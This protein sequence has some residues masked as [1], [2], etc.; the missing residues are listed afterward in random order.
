VTVPNPNPNSHPNPHLLHVNQPRVSDC[1]YSGVV[2]E[3]ELLSGQSRAYI[4]VVVYTMR[5]VVI[6]L[7]FAVWQHSCDDCDV[8][9]GLEEEK[10]NSGHQFRVHD[11][12]T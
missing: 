6:L 11:W 1:L 9:Y 3:C 7:L 12:A 5:S 4:I 2:F 8:C 10:Q